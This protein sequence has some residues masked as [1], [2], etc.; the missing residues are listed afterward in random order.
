MEDRT[1][2][3]IRRALV[4]YAPFYSSETLRTHFEHHPL[5]GT[6]SR[7]TDFLRHPADGDQPSIQDQDE[8]HITKANAHSSRKI[9]KL[10][11]LHAM[12]HRDG[13]VHEITDQVRRSLKY[14]VPESTSPPQTITE[15]PE[16]TPSSI[17]AFVAAHLLRLSPHEHKSSSSRQSHTSSPS[18]PP[19]M[20]KHDEPITTTAHTSIIPRA[21]QTL[22]AN[23]ENF[24]CSPR[25]YKMIKRL[26]H[27]SNDPQ[28]RKQPHPD[29]SSFPGSKTLENSDLSFTSKAARQAVRG[30]SSLPRAPQAL[31]QAL[32]RALGQDV[33]P[34]KWLDKDGT[35]RLGTLYIRLS[36][37]HEKCISSHTVA[38]PLSTYQM[39]TLLRGVGLESCRFFYRPPRKYVPRHKL[40]TQRGGKKIAPMYELL[41]PTFRRLVRDGDPK[42]S[43]TT[44]HPSLKEQQKHRILSEVFRTIARLVLGIPD[45]M[46][47]SDRHMALFYNKY[48][49]NPVHAA[50]GTY[51]A[52]SRR[53]D[54]VPKAYTAKK[55]QRQFRRLRH[56]HVAYAKIK[57]V[58]I[59][60]MHPEGIAFEFRRGTE[61]EIKHEDESGTEDEQT[62]DSSVISSEEQRNDPTDK[63]SDKVIDRLEDAKHTP[64]MNHD[65][66]D[67]GVMERDESD[68]ENFDLPWIKKK[69]KKMDSFSDT[70][71]YAFSPVLDTYDL[72]KLES[73]IESFLSQKCTP[74]QL[75]RVLSQAIVR[76]NE[77]SMP[78][79]P[80]LQPFMRRVSMDTFTTTRLPIIPFPPNFSLDAYQTYLKRHLLPPSLAHRPLLAQVLMLLCLHRGVVVW[81]YTKPLP[82]WAVT[83]MHA[84]NHPTVLGKEPPEPPRSSR[85][86]RFGAC[87]LH[88]PQHVYAL[89]IHEDPTFPTVALEYASTTKEKGLPTPRHIVQYLDTL[90]YTLP[91]PPTTLHIPQSNAYSIQMFGRDQDI[92]TPLPW[93][94]LHVAIQVVGQRQSCLWYVSETNPRRAAH[95]AQVMWF[96]PCNVL[97]SPWIHGTSTEKHISGEPDMSNVYLRTHVSLGESIPALMSL[98]KE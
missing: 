67:D 38:W 37:N 72:H 15:V 17:A 28:G 51:H 48:I 34:S 83:E 11:D 75:H 68:H 88:R 44:P 46:D 59:S 81:D 7:L 61:D 63:D 89:C 21:P 39:Q 1:R 2:E 71:E 54:S 40:Q 73:F 22:H 8:A 25:V 18:S 12:I 14:I 87:L 52:S 55:L 60:S 90:C 97:W 43:T 13:F 45:S 74:S 76:V 80:R 41:G 84:F 24:I 70:E 94:L 6:W 91:D 5:H 56:G 65:S 96:T 82:P 93:T 31:R 66:D 32:Q 16:Q 35:V 50:Q 85:T 20:D 95:L 92:D 3:F 58:P 86:R 78:T 64:E 79:K 33:L 57:R 62:D 27:F 77:W 23:Y 42:R 47:F 49:K 53:T 26:V 4:R 9:P 98:L 69:K 19:P 30:L 29:L 10:K 36:V